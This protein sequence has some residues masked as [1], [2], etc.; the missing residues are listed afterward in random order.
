MENPEEY[1]CSQDADFDDNEPIGTCDE[2]GQ[3]LYGTEDVG[4]GLCSECL[5][6]LI[7]GEPRSD[8][9]IPY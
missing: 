9:D 7:M 4:C 6:S 8:E 1:C 2:C 3:N 5:W